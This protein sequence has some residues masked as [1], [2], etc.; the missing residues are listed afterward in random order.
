MNNDFV[1]CPICDIRRKDLT[2]HITKTHCISKEDF[3]L[4]YPDCPIICESVRQ[5]RS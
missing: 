5:K 1:I 4:R 3:I 2:Q